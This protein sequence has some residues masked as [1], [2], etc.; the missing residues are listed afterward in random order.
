MFLNLDAEI[1]W[2][3]EGKRTGNHEPWSFD[4]ESK[5]RAFSFFQVTAEGGDGEDYKVW[6]KLERKKRDGRIGYALTCQDTEEVLD[7]QR[8]RPLRQLGARVFSGR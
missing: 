5:D 3:L 1:I 8:Y 6:V 4:P 7:E 2:N